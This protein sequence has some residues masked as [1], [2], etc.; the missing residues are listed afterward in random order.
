MSN[1]DDQIAKAKERVKRLEEKKLL[2]DAKKAIAENKNL[3]EQLK[4]KE[5]ESLANSREYKTVMDSV[6]KLYDDLQQVQQGQQ[7]KFTTQVVPITL[8]GKTQAIR[9]VDLE[10][11]KDRL[12]KIINL[13]K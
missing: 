1:I 3:K 9:M 4:N 12:E 2:Q 10:P 13:Q 11:V 5:A 8:Q 7:G 6:K